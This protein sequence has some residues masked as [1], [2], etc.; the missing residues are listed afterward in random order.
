MRKTSHSSNELLVRAKIALSNH[1]LIEFVEGHDFPNGAQKAVIMLGYGEANAYSTWALAALRR[2]YPEVYNE[3]QAVKEWR[4]NNQQR[5]AS[6][7]IAE[8]E[9]IENENGQFT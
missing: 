9:V 3:L 6:K 2:D 1:D 7:G 4:T 5:T 8:K